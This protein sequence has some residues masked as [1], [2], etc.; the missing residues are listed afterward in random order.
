EIVPPLNPYEV[1]FL[2]RFAE[3]RHVYRE[4]GPYAVYGSQSDV[5]AGAEPPPEQPG[6][7]CHWVPTASGD[8]LIFDEEEKFYHAEI[9]L[10]Y[11]IDTFLKPGAVIVRERAEPVAGRFHPPAFEHFTCDH[12]LTGVIDADGDDE[13]DFWRIEVRANEV[14]VVRLVEWPVHADIDPGSPSEWTSVEWDEFS[15]RALHNH[16]SVVSG[17]GGIRR[18][19]PAEEAGFRPVEKP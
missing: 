11:L 2:D 16:V 1:E 9:W 15:R 4:S 6:Y 7:R 5:H 14:N 18:L 3:T 17:N 12:V 19:G 10:A 8:A 13:D